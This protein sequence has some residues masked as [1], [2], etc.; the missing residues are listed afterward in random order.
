M[1]DDRKAGSNTGGLFFKAVR[2]GMQ[3]AKDA[4]EKAKQD[5]EDKKEETSKDTD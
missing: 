5:K 1:A 4:S 3:D 2:A